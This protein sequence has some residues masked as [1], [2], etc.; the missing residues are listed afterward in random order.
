MQE[1]RQKTIEGARIT[2]PINLLLNLW[3]RFALSDLIKANTAVKLRRS[4]KKIV[5]HIASIDRAP[6]RIDARKH[7]R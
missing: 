1:K 5:N 2:E 7:T 6:S 4:K 3:M